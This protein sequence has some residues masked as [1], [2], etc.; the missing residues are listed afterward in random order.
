MCWMS[1]GRN[2]GFHVW[3]KRSG[4]G[5]PHG[6]VDLVHTSRDVFTVGTAGTNRTMLHANDVR[7]LVD[8]RFCLATV[9]EAW[10]LGR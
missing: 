3:T 2:N 6:S 9:A 10:W 7:H 8:S 4:S 5:Y 1:L